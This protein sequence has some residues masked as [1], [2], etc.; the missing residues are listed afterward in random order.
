M[1]QA[2]TAGIEHH[3]AKTADVHSTPAS[4]ANTELGQVLSDALA[5][6]SHGK[7]DIDL[8]LQA[9]GGSHGHGP[10]AE[11]LGGA[12]EAYASIHPNVLAPL[13][14]AMVMHEAAP[15]HA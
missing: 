10:L 15:P 8:L 3:G 5:A 7:P 11:L 12:H 6:G 2:A 14:D 1:L 13:T 9:V 4:S